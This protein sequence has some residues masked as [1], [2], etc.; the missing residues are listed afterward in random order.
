MLDQAAEK[1]ADQPERYQKRVDFFA[2]GFEFFNLMIE[3]IPLMERV[4]DSEGGDAEAVRQAAANWERIEQIAEETA[5]HGF[6]FA[7]V[8]SRMQSGYMGSMASHLGPPSQEQREA[9]DLQ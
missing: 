7:I 1:V 2:K 5:P 3:S 4:R 9:A 8:E 6:W